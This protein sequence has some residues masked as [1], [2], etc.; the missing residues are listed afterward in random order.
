MPAFFLISGL[1]ARKSLIVQASAFRTQKVWTFLWVYSLW[2]GMYA[3]ML[4]SIAR[5]SGDQGLLHKANQWIAETLLVNG[6]LWYLIALP[7]FF[8][9]ARLLRHVPAWVQI[10][11]AGTLSFAFSSGLFHTGQLAADRMAANFVYFL[12]GCY[13]S[14]GIRS[15]AVRAGW[16]TATTLGLAWIGLSV[17]VYVVQWPAIY[18]AQ[19]PN[20]GQ[21]ILPLLA[22]P[23]VLA[24]APL[25]ARRAWANP[26]IWLG[27]NTLPVYVMHLAPISLIAL[28][29]QRTHL[30][31]AG[32]WLAGVLPI[33]VAV[34]ATGIILAIRPLVVRWAPWSLRLPAGIARHQ[35]SGIATPKRRLQ[36]PL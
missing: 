23:L 20:I 11:G 19:L 6:V 1:F 17:G 15:A 13:F 9:A 28:A 31:V 26:L 30:I 10:A 16:R 29:L 24:S 32:S 25:V 21:A 4:E 18:A 35:S 27:R 3:L 22:V 5:M 14:A 36:R 33:L 34:A 8:L 12:I 2:S 7:M